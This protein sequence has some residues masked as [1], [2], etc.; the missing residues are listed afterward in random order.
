MNNNMHNYNLFVCRLVGG[1]IAAPPSIA[2]AAVVPF[3]ETFTHDS[4]NWFDR[5]GVSPVGWNPAGGPDGSAFATTTGSFAGLGT[6]DPLV[7]YRAHDEFNSSGGAFVGNWV[8]DGVTAFGATVRHDADVPLNFFVRF[9]SPANFPGAVNVFFN[10]VP[11]GTWTN[12]LA[13][14]P[15]PNL[16][17]E[18]PFTYNQVF[19]NVGHVQIGVSAPESLAGLNATFAFD[20]DNVS[21]VPEPTTLGLLLIGGFVALRHR[22]DWRGRRI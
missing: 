10:P 16:I 13:P 6:N 3:T 9:A 5:A 21:L 4:S 22:G 17:F 2:P 1:L 12:L 15:N 14:L 20:L 18:G 19:G 11:T 7:L 8:T